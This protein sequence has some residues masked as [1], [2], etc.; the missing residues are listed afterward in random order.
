MG[1]CFFLSAGG[2][3]AHKSNVVSTFERIAVMLGEQLKDPMGR[4]RFTGHLL[5]V[6]G[7]RE[8]A[9]AGIELF[10]IQLLARWKSPVIMRYAAEAPLVAITGDYRKA[11]KSRD[12][13]ALMGIAE[14]A[15][16]DFGDTSKR[17]NDPVKQLA[18]IEATL[19]EL[20]VRESAGVGA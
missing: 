16:K 8:L 15:R 11:S 7:A 2:T 20:F 3:V 9:A 5:R 10:K 13:N 19:I 12:L 17:K 6:M 14:Q 4:R 1:C 18:G